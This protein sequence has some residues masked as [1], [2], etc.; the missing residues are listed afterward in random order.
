M[1]GFS[2]CNIRDIVG[3]KRTGGKIIIGED[4]DY[5]GLFGNWLLIIGDRIKA[6]SIAA[7]GKASHMS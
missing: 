7:E 6:Q 1:V 5:W 4:A 3:E 2:E